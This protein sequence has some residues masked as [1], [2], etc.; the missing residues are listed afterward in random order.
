MREHHDEFVARDAQ[1]LAIAPGGVGN[2]VSKYIDKAGE[3]PFPLLT[4]ARHKTF[5]A[6]DVVKKIAS[7]GQRPALFVID[8]DGV[9]RY[10]QVGTQQTNIPPITEILAELDA[11]T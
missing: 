10:N 1:I 4:D 11:L 9:V 2:S 7:L 8:R 3:F 5:D 6:Y